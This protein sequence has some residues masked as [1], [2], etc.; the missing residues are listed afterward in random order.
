[1]QSDTK[2]ETTY[3]PYRL[4]AELEP[5]RQ[6][7][8]NTGGNTVEELIDALRTNPRLSFSNIIL[9]ELAVAVQS[10]ISLLQQLRKAGVLA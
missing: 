6:M 4:P 5:Y 2:E 3:E 10:Q 9:F 7:I 8:V 1:M